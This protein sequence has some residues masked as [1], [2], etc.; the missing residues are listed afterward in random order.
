MLLDQRWPLDL[1]AREQRRAAIGRRRPETA[2]EVHR[3]LAGERRL[4]RRRRA[5]LDLPWRGFLH[6]PGD[7]RAQADDLGVLLRRRGAVAQ[8]VHLVEQPLDGLTIAALE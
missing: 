4:R 5:A 7:G 8:L 1:V 2:V 3:P 6:Q